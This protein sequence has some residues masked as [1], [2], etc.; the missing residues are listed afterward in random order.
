MRLTR[1]FTAVVVAVALTAGWLFLLGGAEADAQEGQTPQEDAVALAAGWLVMQHENDDGGYTAFSSG[2]G[3]APSDVAGTVDAILALSSAGYNVARPFTGRT[4]SPVAF[5]RDNPQGL[6]AYAAQSGGA[7]GKLILALAAAAQNPRNF[8][9]HN[10]AISLT[11]HLSPTGAYNVATPFDQSLA[12]LAQATVSD[13][14]PALATEWLLQR[15]A[16][17][18]DVAGSWDDGFGTDGNSDATAM[19]VMALVAAG[20]PVSSTALLSAETFLQSTQLESGGWGYAPGQPESANSTALVVQ[21]LAALGRDFYSDQSPWTQE[22]SPLGALRTWQSDSGAFQ[23]DFGEGPADDFF[24]TIQALPALSGRPYPLPSRYEAAQRAVACMATLRDSQSGGWEEFVGS[25][26][27]AGGTSRAMQ[28]LVAAGQ[29]VTGERWAA[30]GLT[31]L[32]ALEDLTPAYLDG[33]RGGRVGIVMQGVQ[34]AGGDVTDFAGYNLPVSMTQY[35]SPTGEYDST[36]FG[37]FSQAEAMLGLLVSGEDVDPLAVEFLLEAQSEDGGW[38][39]PDATGISL[40]V[41]G[42]L[43]PAS[44]EE[45][46]PLALDSLQATQQ[47]DGG[48]G[49]ELPSNPNSTSEV[50]QGLVNVE[51]NPFSPR[52]SQV[53]SGTLR[54]GA[55]LVLAQQGDDGCWPNQFGPG[56]DPFATTDAILLLSQ[57]PPWGEIAAVSAQPTPAPTPTVEATEEAPA[58]AEPT[59]PV[60]P[61][62]QPEVTNTMPPEPSPMATTAPPVSETPEA[63]AGDGG[64]GTTG[65]WIV[66]VAVALLLVAGGIWIWRRQ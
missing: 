28:A 18:G 59:E 45:R 19:A 9:G 35:L 21:A 5:L 23:A 46:L 11:Q 13:S 3:E 64:S 37:P 7:T 65:T 32:E 61:T 17:E 44:W 47:P 16:Q 36:A 53:T 52:W 14:V 57:N 29:D 26:P 66:V 63:A 15:Q 10:F 48:W 24:T 12:I 60:S 39:G 1:L 50:V 4:S 8:A 40:Q 6:S 22:R 33:G 56:S 25:G 2:A 55:T 51:Q 34:A 54:N 27:N 30:D 38:G 58:T 62:V 43:Q 20:E 31:P 42:R 49:F 41:L